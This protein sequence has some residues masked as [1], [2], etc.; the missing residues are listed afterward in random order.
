M[1]KRRGVV[2][3]ESA[4]ADVRVRGK[5]GGSAAADNLATRKARCERLAAV[6]ADAQ[7]GGAHRIKGLIVQ[8]EVAEAL[9]QATAKVLQAAE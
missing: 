6:E 9:Q 7:A 8:D 2:R 4:S 5:E 3:M 1:F